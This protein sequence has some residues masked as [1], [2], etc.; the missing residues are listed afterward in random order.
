MKVADDVWCLRLLRTTYSCT[1]YIPRWRL[2]AASLVGLCTHTLSL[3][4]LA[5][6]IRPRM[7]D[8]SRGLEREMGKRAAGSVYMTRRVHMHDTSRQ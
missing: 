1:H 4:C 2:V 8:A 7:V 6:P 5:Y 3:A